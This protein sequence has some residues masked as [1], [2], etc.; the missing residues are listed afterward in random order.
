MTEYANV[1]VSHKIIYSQSSTYMGLN[2]AGPHTC[3]FFSNNYNI[4]I[5]ILQIF[6]YQEKLLFNERSQ[7]ELG[8]EFRFY[9][10]HFSFLVLGESF[11]NSFLKQR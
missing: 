3:G 11:I 10:N 8:F 1:W 4:C 6:K 2:C 7:V 9:P 5:F